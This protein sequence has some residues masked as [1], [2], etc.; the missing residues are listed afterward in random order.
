ME[1]M[2]IKIW[3]VI[4]ISCECYNEFNFLPQKIKITKKSELELRHSA[5]DE[6]F[7]KLKKDKSGS[8]MTNT[9]GSSLDFD[10][11]TKPYEFGDNL[12]NIA[13][14]ESIKNAQKR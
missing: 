8:H 9:F 10:S 4:A 7:G 3:Q 6:I 13:F 2:K 1:K 14:N 12:E 11:S 5:L